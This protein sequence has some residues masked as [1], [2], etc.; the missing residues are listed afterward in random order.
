M[1]TFF[2]AKNGTK[3]AVGVRW[4]P[5]IGDVKLSKEIAEKARELESKRY[6]YSKSHGSLAGFVSD[7][8]EIPKW[9]GK[10]EPFAFAFAQTPGL[11]D[12]AVFLGKIPGGLWA[13]VILRNGEPVFGDFEIVGEY[14]RLNERLRD[15]L[16][17]ESELNF[18]FYG[19]TPKDKQGDFDVLP[20][21]I[22]EIAATA[23]GHNWKLVSS[24]MSV[25]VAGLII[26][27]ILGAV[28]GGWYYYLGEQERKAAAAAA[29][30]AQ[31]QIDP[32]ELYKERLAEALG[33]SLAGYPAGS[34][35]VTAFAALGRQEADVG[36]WEMADATCDL[37][38]CALGFV[39]GVTNK[40]TFA[41]FAAAK[42]VEVQVD[43]Y[44][45]S[46]FGRNVAA[47]V[48]LPLPEVAGIQNDSIVPMNDFLLETGSRLQALLEDFSVSF[49]EP[50]PFNVPPE[51]AGREAEIGEALVRVGI[52]KVSG[53]WAMLPELV[54]ALPHTMVADRIKVVLSK[55]DVTFTIEGRYYVR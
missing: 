52:W 25:A 23:T 6:F 50:A 36:H 48:K 19:E 9:G 35:A 32:V 54:R 55:D 33:S 12:N 27:L 3:F 26:V 41:S 39:S 46:P 18:V 7:F 40:G 38:S 15:Y 11:A 42:S 28:G 2:E 30:P 37:N 45:I 17:A 49:E 16:A 31:Q 34:M 4:R 20:L 51:I 24:G 53:R 13:L 8:D 5:V 10:A 14:E 44:F 21:T 47:S 1:T 43:R 22:D 29:E